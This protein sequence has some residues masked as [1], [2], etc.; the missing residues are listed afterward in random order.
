MVISL[1]ILYII[2]FVNT[3]YKSILIINYIYLFIDMNNIICSSFEV[4]S[5]I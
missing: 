1:Y 5:Y 3:L 4:E 2:V